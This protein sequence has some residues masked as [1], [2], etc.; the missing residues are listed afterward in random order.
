M[1]F[2]RF[3]KELMESAGDITSEVLYK[4]AIIMISMLIRSK[5]D[6][7][8]Q[9]AFCF[10]FLSIPLPK[11]SNSPAPPPT[12]HPP[13]YSNLSFSTA[14]GLSPWLLFLAD[15]APP[16]PHPA[17]C[18]GTGCWCPMDPNIPSSQFSH[19]HQPPHPPPL[20]LSA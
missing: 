17:G 7:S 5:S 16:T 2:S 13:I 12:P 4:D 11:S 10:C 15:H 19:H 14:A 8:T 9:K 20:A 18:C 6:H 1:N 3:D